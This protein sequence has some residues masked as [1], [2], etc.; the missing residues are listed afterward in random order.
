L[1][2]AAPAVAGFAG[3]GWE[4]S[5]IA[6]LVSAIA[7]ILLCGCS[8]RPR[9]ASPTTLLNLRGH[10]IIGWS[11]LIA[12][13]LHGGGLLLTDP[14]VIEYL[15][16]TTP[17]Y[18][19]AGLVAMLLMLVLVFS[20]VARARRRL[21]N[22]HR[23]FQATHVTFGCALVVLIAIHVAVTDRYAGGVPRRALF[24][25]ITVSAIAL[26]LRARR[27]DDSTLSTRMIRPF[28]FGRHSTW[29]T[30]VV[31][32]ATI[33]VSALHVRTVRAS[34][35][36]PLA[37]RSIRLPLVFPHE[38][39]ATINCLICHHNYADGRGADS[40]VPCHR[41]SRADLRLNA[42][43]RFH[44]FCFDCHRHPEP[45]FKKH[46]P[47]AGCAICHRL[48]SSGQAASDAATPLK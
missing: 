36:E 40:C 35:R 48:A 38:K 22:S 8:V 18:Q 9:D 24:T 46:G 1:F 43:A 31:I 34:L 10:E 29:I 25:G 2:A 16:F 12:G 17:V 32:V 5:Q 3:F 45:V 23:G 15:K 44:G 41:S 33:A 4:L 11:A 26:L 7:C 21:W 47:V 30:W 19:W 37:H 39:H 20:S 27:R 13:A 14:A 42:E 28:V 6:G